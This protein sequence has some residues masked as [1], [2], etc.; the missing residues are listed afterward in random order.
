V[1]SLEPRDREE[2]RQPSDRARKDDQKRTPEPSEKPSVNGK[3][4]AKAGRDKAAA[5]TASV[6]IAAPGGTT[7]G[8]GRAPAEGDPER[9][10]RE[11]GRPDAP[12]VKPPARTAQQPE[13]PASRQAADTRKL[14]LEDGVPEQDTPSREG[15]DLGDMEM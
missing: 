3:Q 11:S 8:T 13:K 6:P 10:A 9:D 7:P 15:P 12:A 2:P 1:L 5:S 14:M 4:G